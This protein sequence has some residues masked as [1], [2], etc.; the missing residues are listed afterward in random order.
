MSFIMRKEENDCVKSQ[1]DIPEYPRAWAEYTRRWLAA[2]VLPLLLVICY[3]GSERVT[4]RHPWTGLLIAAFVTYLI[5]YLRFVQ[6]PC[7][8]CG[9][10]VTM[11]EAH[12]IV[13]A[14]KCPYC[15]LPLRARDF[16]PE[17]K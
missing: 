6:W 17:N 2:W 1:L 7:P 3:V 13:R 8:R 10:R 14:K 11:P 5:L 15:G 16:T 12:R 4:G 9:K